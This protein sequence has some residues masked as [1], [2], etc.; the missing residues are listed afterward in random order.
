MS[1]IKLKWFA[2]E[3]TLYYFEKERTVL[4]EKHC[5]I[6]AH[7]FVHK[8]CSQK[9]WSDLKQDQIKH[10]CSTLIHLLHFW[11][12]KIIIPHNTH[13]WSP[14]LKMH[15]LSLLGQVW[16]V[17][18]EIISIE[19]LLNVLKCPIPLD[20]AY[21]SHKTEW[22]WVIPNGCDILITKMYNLP[23]L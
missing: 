3:N 19:K 17:S 4:S 14:D 9:N 22:K 15:N 13:S 23:W 12:C 21:I 8:F 1:A 10:F 16:P 11:G 20:H 2:I 7:T 6:L 5:S 18:A